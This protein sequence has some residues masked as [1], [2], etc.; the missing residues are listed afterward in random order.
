VCYSQL[1]K[2]PKTLISLPRLPIGIGVKLT[3]DLARKEA[4]GGGGITGLIREPGGPRGG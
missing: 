4:P 2:T 3:R 1:P